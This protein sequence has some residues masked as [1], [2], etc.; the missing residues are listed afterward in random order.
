MLQG[1]SSKVEVEL[2]SA[3][4]PTH[5][6]KLPMDI[7][8]L[9]T[10]KYHI[11]PK[12]LMRINNTFYQAFAPDIYK[13]FKD[14]QILLVASNTKKMRE[15]D[16][17]F[18][19]YGPDFPHKPYESYKIYERHKQSAHYEYEL[20][21]VRSKKDY[22]N[23]KSRPAK[24][25]TDP[26]K[27]KFLFETILT[28]PKSLL[29]ATIKHLTVDVSLLYGYYD[30]VHSK[31][32]LAK[33]ALKKA[34]RKISV[35]KLNV[36]LQPF[37]TAELY[38]S[39]DEDRWG[40]NINVQSSFSRFEKTQAG[41]VSNNK[42]PKNVYF[43]EML[44]LSPVFDYYYNDLRASMRKITNFDDLRYLQNPF[45]DFPCRFG[46]LE[47]KYL[48]RKKGDSYIK[49]ILEH[50]TIITHEIE[51]YNRQ[52]IKSNDFNLL[53]SKIV[54]T[55]SSEVTCQ[56]IDTSL[57]IIGDKE[58]SNTDGQAF[59]MSSESLGDIVELKPVVTLVNKPAK[60]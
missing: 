52:F 47:S 48:I 46:S 17:C 7:W 20:L 29:K 22:S 5:T 25:I 24:I 43:K 1:S 8:Y 53:I 4:K 30:I 32:S 38:D 42:F 9:L 23:Y 18:L 15:S 34:G 55:M 13:D 37:I 50:T 54:E 28:N 40:E 33:K 59:S 60:R 12:L 14:L 31:K 41:I 44:H 21:D 6:G 57:L 35:K 58:D 3:M 11:D 51:I 19:K 49:K 26:N 45:V 56:D 39:F 36:E 16:A 2:I 27:I 10:K